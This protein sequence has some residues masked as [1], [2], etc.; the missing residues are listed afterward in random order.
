MIRIECFDGAGKFIQPSELVFIPEGNH[1]LTPFVNGEPKEI[2]ISLTPENGK[3]VAASFQKDMEQRLAKNVRPFF[4][5]DHNDTGPASALPKSFKYVEGKGIVSEIEWTGAGSKA[6]KAKD[7]SYFSP[8]FLMD[9]DGTPFGL[10]DRGPLGGLVNEPAFRDIPRIAAKDGYF[11]KTKTTKMQDLVKCGLLSSTE[12]AKDDAPTFAAARV[13]AL[14]A[15]SGKVEDLNEKIKALEMERDK[16]KMKVES[17]DASAKKAKE[18][19]V[20]TLIQASVADGRIAA[21]DESTQ[22]FWTKALV[23]CGDGTAAKTFAALPKT[24]KVPTG[25]VVKSANGE[26]VN[27]GSPILVAARACVTAGTA[28]TEQEGIQVALQ[29]DPSLYD[30]YVETLNA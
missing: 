25:Q 1:T 24:V 9:D 22:G 10:P 16:L 19:G 20:K 3:Q 2:K 8:V 28:K 13:N 15:E 27:Y 17:S 29:D 7:Y 4:D 18:D 5:F 11:S 23:E 6:I 14:R 30:S 12:A 26:K 21:K